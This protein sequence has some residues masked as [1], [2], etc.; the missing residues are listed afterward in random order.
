MTP[1]AVVVAARALRI[2][3]RGLGRVDRRLRRAGSKAVSE[4]AMARLNRRPRV[5]DVG[6]QTLESEG[7]VYAP[8]GAVTP[9]DLIGFDPL[10]ERIAQR[11]AHDGAGVT[12][13]PYA[14]GDGGVH[15]LYVNNVDATSSLFPL[16]AAHNVLFEALNEL[17]T[18]RTVEVAT[19]RLDDVMPPGPV[20]FI[21]LDVQGAELMVLQ[22]GP[23]TVGRAAVVHCE[24]EFS[25]IYAGQPLFADVERELIGHGFYLVDLL[26]P[27]RYAYS[28]A[29]RISDRLL[30]ADAVF[31]RATDDRDVRAMQALIA[32]TIYGKLSLA[33][34]LL[35]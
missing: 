24:V 20:D 28:D 26:V 5:V 9:I 22:G 17:V 33:E 30:W 1:R 18:V 3:Q 16:N 19:R 13:L 10:E 23:A 34:H 21:K 14:L 6:A 8:L 11:V 31:F 35:R 15:T 32:A 4:A 7:H 2:Y 12:L 25:P 27:H 29:A